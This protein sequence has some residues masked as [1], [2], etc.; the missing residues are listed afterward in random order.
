MERYLYFR[1]STTAADDQGQDSICYPVSRFLGFNMGAHGDMD[2]TADD[3]L[4]SMA[5]QGAGDHTKVD[6]VA[7]NITTDNNAKDVWKT[8]VNA[9]NSGTEPFIVIGDDATGEYIH[10]DIES[11]GA[12]TLIDQS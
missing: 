2:A 1:T 12:I 8:I 4:F 3:D 6:D 10:P 5:F 7:I 11:I 9:M